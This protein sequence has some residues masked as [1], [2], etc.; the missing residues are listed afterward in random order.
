MRSR[1]TAAASPSSTPPA[2]PSSCTSSPRSAS[3]SAAPDSYAGLRFAVDTADPANGALIARAE[4][5]SHRDQQRAPL[6]R[7]RVGRGRRR[8]RRRAPRR[9]AAR[10][11]PPLPRVGPPV[12]AAPAERARGADPLRQVAH[13]QQRVGAAVLRAHLG[14]HRRPRRR[15]G[16]PR[17]GAVAAACRPTATCGAPPPRRSPPRWSRACAPAAF[18][19]NTLLVDK[20]IDDRLRHYDSWIASRNLGNEASDE[21]VDALVTAV[22]ARYDIPQRWYS[23]KARLLGLDQLADYDRMASVAS[24][25]EEF[26]W[27]E[28]RELVLD[29]YASFSPDLADRRPAVLRRVV[30]RRADAAGQA[31]AARSARTPCRASTRT[32]CSTGRHAGATCSRS[33]TRWVTACT[34]TSPATRGSSTRPRRSRWRRPRRCSARRSRSAASS[35]RPSD[36]D[37]APRAARREPRGPDRDRV[38]PG[39]DEPVRRPR[40]QPASRRGRAVG[41]PVQRGVG[42]HPARRCSATRSRSPTATARGGRTSRTSWARPATCTRTRT[43]SSS[44]CRCTAR[45][46]SRATTSCRATSSC[47]RPVGRVHREELG[48]IVGLDL[49]DPAFWD[50][51]LEIVAEQLAA[52]EAAATEAGRL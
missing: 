50:G 14:D 18:V 41:R 2:S 25:D 30:D 36:P 37:G 34:R 40:A 24:V 45:T 3:S 23:L 46:N 26:G 32:C 48:A 29:A 4:E 22:Q 43:G 35:T 16:E 5:K 21:S 44:R 15:R 1:S 10:V 28:A 19:F 49:A 42:R 33:P 38:P 20:S 39:R 8:P 6:R 51:G 31:A 11:L 9:R 52:A 47:S 17:G 13:R 27:T 7:A 12:P